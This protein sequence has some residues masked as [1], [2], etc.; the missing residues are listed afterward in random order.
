MMGAYAALQYES[1][2]MGR[3]WALW[4]MMFDSETPYSSEDVS[5]CRRWFALGGEI[6]LHTGVVLRHFGDFG[7]LPSS[8]TPQAPPA[9]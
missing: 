5:F 6:W 8:E 1:G 4:S 3:L 7:Y 9:P 2:S